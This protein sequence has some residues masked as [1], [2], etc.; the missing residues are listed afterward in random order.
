MMKLFGLSNLFVLLLISIS[1]YVQAQSF[2]IESSI[3][4]SPPYPTNLDAYVDFLDQGIIEITNSND[5]ALEVYFEVSLIESTGKINIT[6][7]GI[8]GT[9]ITIEPGS[10][11]L[12]PNDIEDIFGGLTES[13]LITGGLSQAERDAIIINRQ[14]PEGSYQLCIKA[15]DEN[16]LPL[17]DPA[18]DGCTSF[19]VYFAE[20]PV[21]LL[22]VEGEVLEAT[23]NIMINWDHNVNS[24]EV[25]T[26]IDYALKII[27]LTEEEV[28]NIELAML[29]PGFPTVYEES[30]GNEYSVNLLDGS[31]LFMESGHTYAVRVTATDPDEQ[32]AFQYG[33]HSEIITFQYG[34]A[35]EE[36]VE[37]TADILDAPILIYPE[38]NLYSDQQP[39]AFPIEW[40]HTVE[41]DTLQSYLKYYIKV[42][43]MDSNKITN[44]TI[45][46]FQNDNYEYIWNKEIIKNSDSDSSTMVLVSDA[47]HQIQ[48]DHMYAMAIYVEVD[49]DRIE[50][51][52]SGY[53]NIQQVIY[54]VKPE[55]T[56][57][58]EEGC[59]GKCIADL[60]VNKTSA[61]I[62]KDDL[63]VMGNVMLA[64][65]K[66][67]D[68]PLG[69]Y[70][71]EGTVLL[72]FMKQ[73]KI[74]VSFSQ[75]KAN[76]KKQ[77]F[78]GTAEAIYDDAI[79]K[80]DG[81]VAGGL[82]GKFDVDHE[83]AKALSGGLRAAGKLASVLAGKETT[84][85]LGFDRTIDGDMMIVGVTEMDFTPTMATMTA[86]VSIENPEWG[87]YIPTLSATD[88]CFR[89]DGFG[90]TVK[91]M[92]TEDY[93]IP[94][95]N[96]HLVL[97]ASENNALDE[98]GTFCYVDC[99]GFKQGQISGEMKVP[100]DV[101]L[102]ENEDGTIAEEGEV[103]ISLS[104]TMM[105]GSGF[106]LSASVS[107][108]QIPGLEGFS[109][110]MDQG[111][112]D[113]SDEVNPTEMTFPQGYTRPEITEQWKGIWFQN[114]ML[115]A[116]MDWGFANEEERTSA[117]IE[118][119][120][121][122]KAGVSVVGSANNLLGIDKGEVAGFAIS[123]DKINL[124]IIRGQFRE[125]KITGKLG[126][127]IL[128]SGQYLD[129]EG[130]V[131]RTE[132]DKGADKSQAN[133]NNSNAA[134][135]ALSMK[136]VVKANEE[137]YDIDY[138]KSHL[139]FEENSEFVFVNNKNEKGFTA[140]MSGSISIKSVAADFHNEHRAAG[141]PEIEVPGIQ[142]EGMELSRMIDKK[143]GNGGNNEKTAFNFKRPTFSFLG[144]SFGSD[145][146]TG[147]A[148]DIEAESDEEEQENAVP[149]MSGFDI[150]ITDFQMGF[151]EDGD[152]LS[153]EK[154]MTEGS[155]MSI[156]VAPVV[157]LVGG[158]DNKNKANKDKGFAISASGKFS[159]TGKANRSSS[160]NSLAFAY[161]AFAMDSL[162]V[163]A[164]MGP[165][166]VAGSL[167][168]YSDDA[169]FGNGMIGDLAVE[170]PLIEVGLEGRFGNKLKPNGQDRYT[171][172]YLFGDVGKEM[173]N[174][175]HLFKVGNYF[176]IYGFHG[177]AYYHMS[178]NDPEA[179]VAAEKYVPDY[180]VSI[181]VRAGLTFSITEPNVLWSKTTFGIEFNQDYG[182]KNITLQG[183]A[184]L[185]QVEPKEVTPQNLDGVMASLNASLNFQ[186]NDEISFSAQLVVYANIADGVIQGTDPYNKVVTSTMTINSDK[187]NFLMGTPTSPGSVRVGIPN[188]VRVIAQ[189][190]LM[191]G[192]GFQYEKPEIPKFIKGLLGENTDSRFDGNQA[193]S[194]Q[195]AN[196]GPVSGFAVGVNLNYQLDIEASIIYAKFRAMFGFDLSLEKRN[197]VTCANTG[198]NEIGMGGYYGE[199]QVYAG[200][201]G[202]IGLDIDLWFYEGRISLATLYAVLLVEG[203]APNPIW[204]RGRARMGYE[205][206]GGLLSGS[207][208]FDVEVG[209]KCEEEL[210][211]PFS[212]VNF[213]AGVK[214]GGNSIKVSV[215]ANPRV[216]FENRLGE[217]SFY[218]KGRYHHF[219]VKLEKF[220]AVK[221]GR[222]VAGTMRVNEDNLS[223]YFIPNDLLSEYTEYDLIVELNVYKNGKKFKDPDTGEYV[224]ESLESRRINGRFW[225]GEH[226]DYLPTENI[227]LT[228]PL[229]SERYYLHGENSKKQGIIALKRSQRK[230][231]EP[232]TPMNKQWW[233]KPQVTVVNLYDFFSNNNINKHI[234]DLNKRTHEIYTYRM[235]AYVLPL[236]TYLVSVDMTYYRNPNWKNEETKIEDKLVVNQLD[237]YVI[238]KAGKT[239]S[240]Y[241]SQKPR[242]KNLYTYFFTTSL[243]NT[244]SQK[245]NSRNRS[246]GR[247]FGNSHKNV[248]YLMG[249]VEPFSE[250]E[251]HKN[252]II[253]SASMNPS[254][255]EIRE[256]YDHGKGDSYYCLFRTMEIYQEEVYDFAFRYRFDPKGFGLNKRI[257][258][259]T[260][261]YP[262]NGFMSIDSRTWNL[263]RK[264][265]DSPFTIRAFT[266][267]LF[268]PKDMDYLEYALWQNY[269]NTEPTRFMEYGKRAMDLEWLELQR[270]V[271]TAS[272]TLVLKY[273]TPII[274]GGYIKYRYGDGH[275]IAFPSQN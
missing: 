3:A 42:I 6:S 93:N 269:L 64:V 50:W 75:L 189:G 268:T 172:W 62:A 259:I 166:K 186:S 231:F 138:L 132:G 227:K 68:D 207:T 196:S 171:Y 38:G 116:P 252:E 226:P 180:N 18:M 136:F 114:V 204:A 44:I 72:N 134:S 78:E 143:K 234:V 271:G 168:F 88:I 155:L 95:T 164:E 129:Y 217:Y 139:K 12:T 236:T 23:E 206:F 80:A 232:Y 197:G 194:G 274:Y 117:G 56:P 142:F 147:D 13:E 103:T 184:Y 249:T 135:E 211:N 212:G 108:C 15:F 273:R 89:G 187:W 43:D 79:A 161:E 26:R 208:G 153:D 244:F 90:S 94:L 92:L 84:L 191:A 230:L 69:G 91:L 1:S 183:N 213:I 253:Q 10:N 267:E 228:Y 254:L 60:P 63:L 151:G 160:S 243:F 199:G 219:D 173:S 39:L 263:Y 250:Q 152:D 145:L 159:I 97:K 131:D 51:A 266:G 99:D 258:F 133:N 141:S 76:S 57:E 41:E 33:G 192:H 181:G 242:S 121:K 130:L 36:D 120:I 261:D 9:P 193:S 123:I 247:N 201:R 19:D 222:K 21:I 179:R 53:S 174:G 27:D 248:S 101:L 148:F 235:P 73:V 157:M 20:R 246:L 229:L 224:S 260:D 158:D 239:Y 265:V 167:G 102:P 2:P 81:I 86:M 190:Y 225:T 177:G 237:N 233:A 106:I 238:K 8:L 209:E 24:A 185:L 214:P 111:Y 17:S 119:F 218:S 170:M 55:E 149:K 215:Y 77:V 115:K 37:E 223:A 165:I 251:V 28:S 198:G 74:K 96:E 14:M 203:G 163:S 11:L 182:V 140:N 175:N 176:S 85:P 52:E 256:F 126:L 272:Q 47:Q 112:Y 122:D 65:K 257:R 109:L 124:D 104:G 100:R 262:R 241:E 30:L 54:Q 40:S 202:E 221:K 220:E 270:N 83:A 45:E 59:A 32:L 5:Q 82:S 255:I 7:N 128:G 144:Q 127:P 188:F 98:K 48:Y 61:P 58:D 31:D 240:N 216:T 35:E 4:L 49:D 169:T 34:E 195:L 264:G 110:V 146:N 66:V 150:A 105:K 125:A 210:G 67:E 22:P 154:T 137:G 205:L 16:G 245:I 46:D 113:G 156:V 275:E 29:D 178:D 107:P 87:D 200:L 71:G 118:H 25:Q 162:G 70:K